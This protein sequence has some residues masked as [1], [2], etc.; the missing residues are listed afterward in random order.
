MGINELI[1]I[2]TR[3]K[4]KRMEKGYSQKEM[5]ASLGIPDSTYSNYE[6]NYR[7]PNGAILSK[8]VTTLEVS[9]DELVTDNNELQKYYRQFA[10]KEFPNNYEGVL[11][12]ISTIMNSMEVFIE[13]D[14]GEYAV[15]GNT[16]EGFKI[17]D[18]EIKWLEEE[19]KEYSI[20]C[21][22]KLYKK[23]MDDIE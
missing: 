12:A 7:E 6:N 10:S 1:N 15:F 19:I 2:G 11:K 14:N 5:A 18:K 17:S 22:E 8:I 13:E 23:H 3:I 4:Q 20:F 9:L 21:I 16:F